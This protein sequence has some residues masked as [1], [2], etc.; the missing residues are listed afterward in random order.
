MN[1]HTHIVNMIIKIGEKQ[2]KVTNKISM[3]EAAEAFT[4][5]PCLLH[6]C[7]TFIG[8]SSVINSYINENHLISTYIYNIYNLTFT[9]SIKKYGI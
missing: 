1:L 8:V 9:T 3:R 7:F 5:S 2:P 4:S 6:D